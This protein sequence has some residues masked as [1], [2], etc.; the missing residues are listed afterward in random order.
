[1][2]KS[3]VF[4]GL[5]L[6]GISK[7]FG[8]PLAGVCGYDFISQAA[9]DIDPQ[10]G[11]MVILKPGHAKLPQTGAWTRMRFHSN[12]PLVECGFAR[13]HRGLFTID[14]GSNSTVDFCTPS[15]SRYHMLEGRKTESAGTLGAGGTAESL[16]GSIEWFDLCGNRFDNPTVTFQKSMIGTYSDQFRDGNVGMGFMMKRR[17]LLDYRNYRLAFVGG[18]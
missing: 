15:V 1:M 17:I 11:K 12:V 6:A 2:I 16:S 3:P 4:Y 9:L 8:V 10:A 18:S 14:T 5:P 13:G 7:V